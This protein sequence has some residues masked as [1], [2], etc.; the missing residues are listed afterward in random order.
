MTSLANIGRRALAWATAGFTLVLVSSCG[1]GDEWP[2][3]PSTSIR[4]ILGYELPQSP[5]YPA[6]TITVSPPQGRMTI[7]DDGPVRVRL[8]LAG[9]PGQQ[10]DG[11][12]FE[13]KDN[14]QLKYVF[15]LP[16]ALAPETRACTAAKVTVTSVSGEVS[17]ASFG[18]CAGV[19]L[20]F[21][22]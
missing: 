14:P 2:A 12:N 1:G 3:P 10:L 7:S 19:G 21:E 6:G 5:V 11:P 13:P 15:G 4:Y 9:F 18:V 20:G 17:I 8:E 16:Q 22:A